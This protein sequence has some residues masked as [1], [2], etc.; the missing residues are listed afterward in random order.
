M[1]HLSRS[2]M[3]GL[4]CAAL[5]FAFLLGCD[6]D[7]DESRRPLK[8]D[9]G[10]VTEGNQTWS[11]T[12]T[13]VGNYGIVGTN[14]T[15]VIVHSC[16]N[17]G[18]ATALFLGTPSLGGLR[19]RQLDQVVSMLGLSV[20]MQT[21]I[22]K[23]ASIMSVQAQ[24]VQGLIASGSTVTWSIGAAGGFA[25]TYGTAGAPTQS[26]SLLLNSKS[27][28]M[29]MGSPLGSANAVTVYAA[30]TGGASAGNGAFTGGQVRVVVTYHDCSDLGATEQ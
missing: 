29:V 7:R 27:A 22:P 25:N 2:I 6:K 3:S 11:G 26:D 12:K 1:K 16:A 14:A 21:Q 4:L 13:F 18:P 9:S 17:T 5:A 10:A 24:V 30:A 23:G 28:T 15:A 8:V 20:A 19:I